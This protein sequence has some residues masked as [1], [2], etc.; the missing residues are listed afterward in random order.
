MKILFDSHSTQWKSP[1]GTLELHQRCVIRLGIAEAPAPQSVRLFLESTDGIQLSIPMELEYFSSEAAY[2]RVEFSLFRWGLYFYEFQIQ[3]ADTVLLHR[4][5]DGQRWQVS[6]VPSPS[7]SPSQYGQVM[8]QIF[9]DRFCK[10]GSCDLSGKLT[11]FS[12]HTDWE[13]PPVSP[14][15]AGSFPPCTD[16]FG[17]NLRGIQEKLPYLRQ[18][19]IDL[20]YCNPIFLAHSN[21]RYDTAD[22]RKIDPM[23]GTEAD[24]Q[25]LCHAVHQA[26]MRIILDGV[27]SHTG[28]NS[29]Y[30]DKYAVFGNGACSGPDSPYYA[31]YT[32][33]HFPDIYT[34]WWGIDS[35]PAVQELHPDYLSAIIEAPDSVVAHWL[36]LGAD[37]FRLDV[38]DELPDEFIARLHRRVH[39]IK[40][41]GIVI[42]E[43]WEDASNKISY[44]I[45]RS[46]FTKPELDTVM[47]YPVRTAILDFVCGR[48]NGQ[49]LAKTVMTLAEHY[50]AWAL[51]TAMNSLST[52]DTPRILTVLGAETDWKQAVRRLKLAAFLQF[53]LPGSPCIFYGDEAGLTGAGDPDCRRCYPWNAVNPTLLAYYQR[54]TALKRQWQS[55]RQGAIHFQ[56][57]TDGVILFQRT[58]ESEV[59]TCLINCSAQTIALPKTAACLFSTEESF[60]ILPPYSACCYQTD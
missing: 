53:T 56:T 12:V 11:P 60:Q 38:A 3:T 2:Y 20:L 51:H 15:S 26:G 52:H 46:Y 22:Y 10:A 27:F 49:T 24:F 29:R 50:P 19:G 9:P 41:D 16:F 42:G 55:L 5:A 36:R 35:L 28:S 57:T 30:F 58:L 14:D 1:F 17:G 34:S 8:Y 6:C 40:P 48:D 59:L 37:G 33:Q 39:E 45:R 43:V 7:I 23:L 31:W 13:E 54:L 21:H 32:F 44:D 47:N 18:L 4:M 25:S